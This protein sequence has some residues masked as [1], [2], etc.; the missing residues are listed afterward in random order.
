MNKF[1]K[2]AIDAAKKM[3]KVAWIA[4]VVLP[5]GFPL[6]GLYLASKSLYDKVSK[7]KS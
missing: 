2:D 1:V 3:P 4:A 5:G 6:I 7:K